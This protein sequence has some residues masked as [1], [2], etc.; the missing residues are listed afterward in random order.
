ME[1]RETLLKN[2]ESRGFT[3]HQFATREEASDFILS[4]VHDTTVGIGGS[5]T[6]QEMDLYDR[7]AR[8]NTVYWHWKVKGAE[9]LR[10]ANAS[11]AYICSVNGISE[12]GEM[13]NIDGTGNRVAATLF[14]PRRVFLVVGKNKIAPDLHTAIDRARN[15][16]SP[17]NARR[18]GIKTP[19]VGGELK[20]YDCKSPERICNAMVTTMR[21]PGA[22]KECHVIIIEE[23]LGY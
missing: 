16:A 7:L 18:L 3:P 5:I 12:A 23:D 17:L 10:N 19:C 6:V 15:I 14:G 8:N 9:T 4:Q 21:K 2:L 11:D 20:C 22:L 13:V 1:N